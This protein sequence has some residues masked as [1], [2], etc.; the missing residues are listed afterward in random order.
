MVTL[1]NTSSASIFAGDLVEWTL[2]YGKAAQGNAKRARHGPR[3]IGIQTATVSSPKVIG[4]ALSFAKPGEPL[5]LVRFYSL[6]RRIPRPTLPRLVPD[7]PFPLFRSCSS[8]S[9]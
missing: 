5:D 7:I 2:S 9:R 8:S 4:R 1:L 3:R 6:E